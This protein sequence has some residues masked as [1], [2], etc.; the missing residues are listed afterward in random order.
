MGDQPWPGVAGA[1]EHAER[2][3]EPASVQ[4]RVEITEARGQAPA[5]L[6]IR[7]RM[8][9]ARQDPATV[10]QAEQRIELLDELGGET[11]VAERPDRHGVAGG[12]LGCDLEDRKRD[13]EPAADVDEA[14][15]TGA[16]PGVPGRAQLLDQAVLE[17]E[18]PELRRRR[19]VVDDRRVCRPFG[20]GR[21]GGEMRARPAPDRDRLADVQRLAGGVAE[22]V[23]ARVLRQLLEVE[24]RQRVIV[25]GAP[26]APG[27]LRRPGAAR[28][29]RFQERERVGDR[30]GVGAQPGEQ[31]AQ[32]P[33]ARLRVRE[34]AMGDADLDAERV[35]QGPEPALALERE[36]VPCQRRGADD[37][38]V[39][40]VQAA[41]IE[42]LTEHAAVKRRVVGDHDAPPQP[43]LELRQDGLRR[44]GAVDH[45]LRNPGESLDSPPQWHVRPHERGPCL[46]EFAPADEHRP[47]LGQLAVV[48]A[49][50]I[51]LG[52]DGQELGGSDR[53][54]EQFQTMRDTPAPGRSERAVAM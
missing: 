31:G 26:R 24:L 47:D 43:L 1:A 10:A 48:A 21:R 51:G 29:A 15:I 27:G 18:R 7:R 54:L 35:G 4:I 9:A 6:A 28:A 19:A 25:R 34:R 12:R 14:V 22:Q 44:R 53:L 41:P 36:H 42:R 32:D 40:P 17:H 52:V 33:P 2:G 30:G 46:V 11:P 8:L 20:A 37:R 49:E 5:H 3:V 38:R 39:R 16:Q 13:V 45:L 50:P 23:D